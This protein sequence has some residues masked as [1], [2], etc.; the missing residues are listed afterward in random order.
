VVGK[1]ELASLLDSLPGFK[2]PKLR[3]EQYI[4]PGELA[5]TIAWT[6]YMRGEL[7][8]GWIADLGCGTGRLAYA[9]AALGGRSVCID[10]DA[11]ALQIARGL[12]LDVAL[13][14]AE[15]PCVRRPVKVVMNPPFGVWMPHGDVRFLRGAASVAEIIYSIHKAAAVEYV[16]RAARSLGLEPQLLEIAAMGIPPMYR[17]HRKRRHRVEVAVLRLESTFRGPRDR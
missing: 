16:F 13:C 11:D 14:D 7:A 15:M 17:H 3:L 2:R 10:I 4:T 8:E 1:K 6:M 5:A 12:G 9:V